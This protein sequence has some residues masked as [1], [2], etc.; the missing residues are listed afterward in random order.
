M[1]LLQ[2]ALDP[3]CSLLPVAV[4]ALVET[5][6]ALVQAATPVMAERQPAALWPAAFSAAALA[7]AAAEAGLDSLATPIG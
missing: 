6:E 1:A 4:S 5:A 7:V 2:A 3:L